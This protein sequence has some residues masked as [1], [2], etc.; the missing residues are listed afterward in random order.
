MPG[1][2]ISDPWT[3]VFT[4]CRAK[5]LSQSSGNSVFSPD[6]VERMPFWDSIRGCIEPGDKKSLEWLISYCRRKFYNDAEISNLVT[7]EDL[8]EHL[9][10][11]TTFFFL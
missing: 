3:S 11:D 10:R 6:F 8:L 2:N 9:S 5:M 1:G 7:A 4:F